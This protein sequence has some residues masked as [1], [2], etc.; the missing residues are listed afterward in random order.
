MANVTSG[1]R[2]P[3]L[4]FERRVRES[5]SGRER[6]R[7]WQQLIEVTSNTWLLLPALA[8]PHLTAVWS[9]T[10]DV[11]PNYRSH[12]TGNSARLF[13]A[14][15]RHY[16]WPVC[17]IKAEP[18]RVGLS[19]G[20]ESWELSCLHCGQ[21]ID[22]ARALELHVKW[23]LSCR[24]VASECASRQG[25]RSGQALHNSQ[26]KLITF[27]NIRKN[28]HLSLSHVSL[29]RLRR[30]AGTTKMYPTDTTRANAPSELRSRH[31]HAR[32]V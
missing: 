15:W 3:Q 25:E 22:F 9:L 32:F 13:L 19:R 24:S 1:W 27:A 30:D 28:T 26:L 20:W 18:S 7:D 2:I 8:T 23:Q 14:K 4:A 5:G 12:C 17:P 21:D 10:S 16:P 29:S 11:A 31:A 6:G